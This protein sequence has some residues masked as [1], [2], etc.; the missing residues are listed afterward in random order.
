[1]GP[2]KSEAISVSI[3]KLRHQITS[4]MNECEAVT[5]HTTVFSQIFPQF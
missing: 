1:M 3:E 2:F 4:K 5:A